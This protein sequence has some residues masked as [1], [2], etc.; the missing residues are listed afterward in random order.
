MRLNHVA[1]WIDQ[2]EHLKDFYCRY[3]SFQAGERYH[4]ASK[5]F[6]SYFLASSDHEAG[7]RIELMSMPNIPASANDPIKQATGLIHIAISVG[8][9]EAVVALTNTMARNDI[10]VIDPPHDTGDGYFESCVLDPDGNR[11]EITI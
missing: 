10:R 5:G 6:S 4:N 1:I 3:F 2:L 8:S 9:R 7:A 11:V